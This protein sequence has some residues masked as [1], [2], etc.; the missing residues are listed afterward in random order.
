MRISD[1]LKL[2]LGS[3]VKFTRDVEECGVAFGRGE[4][5][6]VARIDRHDAS[7]PIAVRKQTASESGMLW[8]FLSDV[9]L[10]DGEEA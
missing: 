10:I 4:L 1:A 7:Q 2:K 9:E 5:A 3:K 8:P 6:E